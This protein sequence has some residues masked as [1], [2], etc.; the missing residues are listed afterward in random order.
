MAIP[1]LTEFSFR[2]SPKGAING[3]VGHPAL[4]L[5]CTGSFRPTVAQISQ[6]SPSFI[7]LLAV[8]LP[9]HSR[10]LLQTTEF[11][12][13][14]KMDFLGGVMGMRETSCGHGC[15]EIHPILFFSP[16]L[17]SSIGSVSCRA[18][19]SLRT[20]LSPIQVSLKKKLLS[21]S[22]SLYVHLE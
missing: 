16:S 20:T 22:Y 3:L 14:G 11:H 2:R 12:L 9:L 21:S 17:G 1:C 6:Y 7:W 4:S 5:V 8:R 18:Q 19:H 10:P 13:H 15:V